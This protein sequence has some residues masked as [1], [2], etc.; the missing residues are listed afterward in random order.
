MYEGRT[1]AV[2][3]RSEPRRATLWHD[4]PFAAPQAAADQL[5]PPAR[6]APQPRAVSDDVAGQIGAMDDL[7]LAAIVCDPC[8]RILAATTAAGPILEA[9]VMLGISAGRLIAIDPQGNAGLRAAI[10][11]CS[12][13][14]D[15]EAERITLALAGADELPARLDLAP[16][17]L[18]GGAPRCVI[19]ITENRP[20][21]HAVQQLVSAFGLTRAEAEVAIDLAHGLSA[22]DIAASR[23]ASS[24]TVRKQTQAIFQ[25]LGVSKATRLSFVIGPF[26]R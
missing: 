2:P 11:R 18:H 16:L 15:G 12:T 1:V 8:G 26:L 21:R 17:H 13:V 23:A 25:K 20:C 5:R 9:Q 7:G 6:I 4:R 24:D 10:V 19:L 3:A 22:R 14:Q